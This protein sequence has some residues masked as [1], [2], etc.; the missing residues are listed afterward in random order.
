[1]LMNKTK[2]SND[3]LIEHWVLYFDIRAHQI[4]VGWGAGEGA[5]A[6]SFQMYKLKV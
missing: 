4:I 5:G 1:M 3:L 6:G 2:Y